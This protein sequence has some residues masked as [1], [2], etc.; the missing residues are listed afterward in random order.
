MCHLYVSITRKE[1]GIMA[2]LGILFTHTLI[3]DLTVNMAD[4]LFFLT[5]GY[6]DLDIL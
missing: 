2:A 6:H 5:I 3:S 4:R 1:R